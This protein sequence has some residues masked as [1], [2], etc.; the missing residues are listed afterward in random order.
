MLVHNGI[1]SLIED[2]IFTDMNIIKII[3]VTIDKIER[4]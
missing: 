1:K 4:D 2:K 3:W